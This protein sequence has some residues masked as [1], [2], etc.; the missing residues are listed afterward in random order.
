MAVGLRGF[1][2]FVSFTRAGGVFTA[3]LGVTFPVTGIDGLDEGAELV[4][5][6][7]FATLAILSLMQPGSLL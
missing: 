4:E 5:I 6:V 1:V 7:W 2:G 3:D